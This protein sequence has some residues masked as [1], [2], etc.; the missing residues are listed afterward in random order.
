M[1]EEGIF[2]AVKDYIF[3][4]FCIDCGLEGEWW[5]VKCRKNKIKKICRAE[6]ELKSLTALFNY[7]DS[8]Q[9][10]RLIKSFKY[11]YVSDIAS[12]WADVIRES[13]VKFTDDFTIV[14]IPLYQKRLRERGYNQAETIG[15]ILAEQ[16]G[17]RMKQ[18]LLVRTR[19]TKQQARLGLTERLDNIKGAFTVSSEITLKKVLL[20]DDV[21]TSGATMNECVRV[22]RKAGV[23]E[24]HGFVLAH[25]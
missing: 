20:V 13:G 14:P 1:V 5:C 6:G 19:E 4:F 23:E 24:I 21:Y 3:P 12:L 9:V 8:E 22:L 18:D 16:T 10:E 2:A 17:C 7:H 11:G 25:G 15:K